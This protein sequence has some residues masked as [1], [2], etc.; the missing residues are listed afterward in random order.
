LYNPNGWADSLQFNYYRAPALIPPMDWVDTIAPQHP[1]ISKVFVDED[2]GV[3][4]FTVSGDGINTTET[5]TIKNFVVYLSQSIIGLTD[6]PTIIIPADASLKFHFLV[7]STLID[8]NW[9]NCYVAVTSVDRENNESEASNVF[10][11]EK[12]NNGWEV[13]K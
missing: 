6:H 12:N 2:N 13:K 7:Q 3:Q 4:Q 5:E 10:Q 9:K 11:L 8:K 1:H